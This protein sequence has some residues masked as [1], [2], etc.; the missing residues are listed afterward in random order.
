MYHLLYQP[1]TVHFVFMGLE[2]FSLRTAILT[3]NRIKHL[4]FAMVKSGV[5]FEVWTEFLNIT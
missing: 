4:I 3:L 1:V 2:L 5:L